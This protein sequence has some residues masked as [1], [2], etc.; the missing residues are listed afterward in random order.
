M[1]EGYYNNPNPA[2]SP[3]NSNLTPDGHWHARYTYAGHRT[4]RIFNQWPLPWDEE[5][6]FLTENHG[7]GKF[8]LMATA[9]EIKAWENGKGKGTAKGTKGKGKQGKGKDKGKAVA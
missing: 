5:D 9:M 7:K 1:S 6:A 3:W 8:F 2:T 4:L